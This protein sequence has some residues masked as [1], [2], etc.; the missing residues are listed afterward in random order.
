[1]PFEMSPEDHG[2]ECRPFQTAGR[3]VSSGYLMCAMRC[4]VMSSPCQVH[5]T[6]K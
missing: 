4:C 3:R 5:M 6:M 2:R 1:M